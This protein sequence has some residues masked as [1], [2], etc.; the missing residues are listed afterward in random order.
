MSIGIDAGKLDRRIVVQQRANDKDSSG[1]RSML[2]SDVTAMW[3]RIEQ[4]QGR[5]LELAQ[6]INA[7]ITHR[8]TVRYRSW[9][10][11]AHRVIYQGRVMGIVAPPIDVDT[12]HVLL[13]LMCSEGINRG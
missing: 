4:L 12:E 9:I 3:A 1:Q 6:A 7:E 10:T 2:W 13:H 11:A 8:I 5:E